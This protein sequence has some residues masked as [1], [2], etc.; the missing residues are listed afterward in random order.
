MNSNKEQK[1]KEGYSHHF[2]ELHSYQMKEI[3]ISMKF[4]VD[5]SN[6]VVTLKTETKWDKE[7]QTDEWMEE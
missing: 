2:Y 7:G 3:Y 5:I 1:H 4:Q 6:I